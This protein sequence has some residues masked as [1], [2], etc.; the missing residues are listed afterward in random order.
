MDPNHIW[1]DIEEDIL[2]HILDA[3]QAKYVDSEIMTTFNLTSVPSTDF[4]HSKLGR[5]Q[6]CFAIG[7]TADKSPEIPCLRCHQLEDICDSC[8]KYETPESTHYPG[9]CTCCNSLTHEIW[10]CLAR[11]LCVRCGFLGH[12]GHECNLGRGRKRR[13]VWRKSQ[14]NPNAVNKQI[15]RKQIWVP[16][17][18][19]SPPNPNKSAN[20]IVPPGLPSYIAA[21]ADDFVNSRPNTEYQLYRAEDARQTVLIMD[22][23]LFMYFLGQVVKQTYTPRMAYEPGFNHNVGD[24]QYFPVN[25][26]RI[27]S[28]MMHAVAK[29]TEEFIPILRDPIDPVLEAI[30][31]GLF[32]DIAAWRPI[33]LALHF[34]FDNDDTMT[35]LCADGFSPC[36]PEP[37]GQP[38]TNTANMSEM[39]QPQIETH[40]S[41]LPLTL[42][43]SNCLETR[44]DTTN[45]LSLLGTVAEKNW[46][47]LTDSEIRG[48]AHVGTSNLRRSSRANK[49][50]GF[51]VDHPTDRKKAISKVKPRVIPSVAPAVKTS[52]AL[53]APKPVADAQPTSQIP[54]PT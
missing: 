46:T 33:A 48:G 45:Q 13:Y 37:L 39:A 52:T 34:L 32:I 35:W 54:P 50:D 22:T 28:Q 26:L 10:L 7:H 2:Y 43:D 3:R 23:P 51:K 41:E 25:P 11:L 31:S 5:C 15:R 27:L 30:N 1:N 49:Y 12:L 4:I 20:L 44:G 18:K 29:A 6:T 47:K 24:L 53:L 21:T 42:A 9:I 16:K 8:R 14:I 19:L 36:G 38:T 17:Q 40:T